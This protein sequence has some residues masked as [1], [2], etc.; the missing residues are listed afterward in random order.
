MEGTTEFVICPKD[1]LV[2]RWAVWDRRMKRV[3]GYGSADSTTLVIGE[4]GDAMLDDAR[5]EKRSRVRRARKWD[6]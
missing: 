5:Q 4:S 1:H 2:C 3:I 6:R